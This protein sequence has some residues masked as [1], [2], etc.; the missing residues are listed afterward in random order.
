LRED[1]KA[2]SAWNAEPFRRNRASIGDADYRRLLRD[3]F[4]EDRTNVVHALLDSGEVRIG[5]PVG[6]AEPS[7]VEEDQARKRC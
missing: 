6:E 3:R 5:N 7:L 4:V 1:R 2:H